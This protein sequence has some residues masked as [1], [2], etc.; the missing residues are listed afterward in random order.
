MHTYIHYGPY[1]LMSYIH[2]YIDTHNHTKSNPRQTDKPKQEK[3]QEEEEEEEE[4][5]DHSS[6]LLHQIPTEDSAMVTLSR[7]CLTGFA[8]PNQ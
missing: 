3:T 2:T 6:A 4:G 5:K 8:H 1:T 7:I